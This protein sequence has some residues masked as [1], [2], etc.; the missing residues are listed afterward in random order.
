M[1][2]ARR[3]ELLTFPAMPGRPISAS[4]LGLSVLEQI[5]GISKT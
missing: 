3:L 5:D 2:G 4:E 1:V